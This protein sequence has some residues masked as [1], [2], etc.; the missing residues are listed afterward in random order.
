MRLWVLGPLVV[1]LA[2]CSAPNL[3]QTVA[4]QPA[5]SIRERIIDHGNWGETLSAE[6][7]DQLA[8]FIAEYAGDADGGQA[9]TAPGLTVWKANECGSCHTLAAAGSSD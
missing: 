1:T 3:D 4:G 6:E 2:A 7:L 9:A 5:D 8:G